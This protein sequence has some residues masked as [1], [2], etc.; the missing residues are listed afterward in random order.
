MILFE[1]PRLLKFV[2]IK[3]RASV[4]KETAKPIESVESVALGFYF[5]LVGSWYT[6]IYP[7]QSVS[8]LKKIWWRIARKRWRIAREW[9]L[10]IE[11]DDW[12]FII[13]EKERRTPTKRQN[14]I[15]NV[16][17]CHCRIFG[18]EQ[19]ANHLS[20]FCRKPTF[21][22]CEISKYGND[23]NHHNDDT[24]T[25]SYL[26]SSTSWLSRSN[27]LSVRLDTLLKSFFDFTHKAHTH[28]NICSKFAHARDLFCIFS[29][30]GLLCDLPI[31]LLCWVNLL[32]KKLP[33]EN[34]AQ[35]LE[36]YSF[37]L[38]LNFQKKWNSII[39]FQWMG[40]L[41][42]NSISFHS[43]T[44]NSI[45]KIAIFYRKSIAVKFKKD[46]PHINWLYPTR[47]SSMALNNENLLLCR[48]EKSM[49][50]GALKIISSLSEIS[51]R[52][53]ENFERLAFHSPFQQQMINR[54]T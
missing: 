37:H 10:T 18:A 13:S 45:R 52:T 42:I 26:L 24:R 29:I 31:R 38:F 23:N 5:R 8:I 39:S 7:H 44:N 49:Q 22:T 30:A 28:H 46:W 54:S 1:F 20:K 33:Y 9:K 34:Y 4:I 11:N 35:L 21:G 6:F 32:A 19:T 27:L 51:S 16:I 47:W 12:N 15:S 2:D 50:I 3:R 14:E 43:S 48:L 40:E 36:C 53:E 25:T 41:N 17:D